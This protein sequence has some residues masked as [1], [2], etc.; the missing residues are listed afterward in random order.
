MDSIKLEL[1]VLFRKTSFDDLIYHIGHCY[2]NIIIYIFFV[3]P[4]IFPY[5]I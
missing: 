1:S 3:S 5:A 2:K 4:F